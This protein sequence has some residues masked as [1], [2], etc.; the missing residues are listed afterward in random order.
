M[1]TD[2]PGV[3]VH[4]HAVP[5]G[6]L[7]EVAR[8]PI[9]GVSV[10]HGEDGWLVTYPGRK[11]LR[12]VAG[13]MLDFDERLD[14]LDSQGM[15]AQVISPWLDVHGQE[16]PARDGRDWVRA[17]NDAMAESVA[18]HPQRLYAYATLH[19]EDVPMAVEELGRSVRELGITSCM[20]PTHPPGASLAEPRFDALWEAAQ[21]LGVTVT[22][23]PPMLSPSRCLFEE[24]ASLKGTFGRGIDTMLAAGNLILAGVFDRF[25][26]L[27]MLL[28]HG[29]G[30]LPYQ[31]G[32]FDRDFGN[33]SKGAHLKRLPSEYV[34]SLYYDSVLLAGPTMSFL[35]DL[36]GADRVLIGSD[37]GARPKERSGV[38]LTAGLDTSKADAGARRKV[39]RE[40]ADRL[41]GTDGRTAA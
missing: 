3:D 23:H 34:K 25:P 38:A 33:T 5:E 9:G 19:L 30:F 40:N 17:L 29:G 18:A 22:L 14:W 10:E 12:T 37:Y 20:L 32:R 7:R 28:V 35:L 16:L 31:T 6:F 13:I 2:P 41:F 39:L 15:E 4:A 27:R 36:V 8:S 21:A 11:P 1:N 26:D 24:D